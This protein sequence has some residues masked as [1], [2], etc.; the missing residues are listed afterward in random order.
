MLWLRQFKRGVRGNFSRPP[1]VPISRRARGAWRRASLILIVAVLLC[2]VTTLRATA[3]GVASLNLC[4]D[5][6]LL[7]LAPDAA[8]A[9]ITTLSRDPALSPFAIRAR[10]LP[11]LHGY[12]EEIVRLQ[13]ALTLSGAGSTSATNALLARLGVSL[14][15]FDAAPDLAAFAENFRRVGGYLGAHERTEALLA[16]M[17]RRLERHQKNEVDP[18]L[19][20]L[21]LEPNGYAPGP[22]T[23]AD[24]LLAAVGMTNQAAALGV[25]HGGF[26]TL[27]AL[28]RSPPAWLLVSTID[29]SR[30]ALANEFLQHPVLRQVLANRLRVLAVPESLWACGGTY[31]A[32][33]VD[34]IAQ[35]IHAA[36]A[37]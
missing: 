36:A 2:S 1:N 22:D 28:V 24:D 31:F 15:L 10:T 13:P 4:T 23:L 33:A 3:A 5:S 20:A 6:M 27:E 30:P 9:A 12:A 29:P 18:A 19:T 14:E 7:E 34:F 21:V 25:P 37:Q 16:N 32:D 17:R 35:N 26:V 8:I 11:V